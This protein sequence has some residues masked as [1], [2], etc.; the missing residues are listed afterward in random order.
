LTI[1]SFTTDVG[2]GTNESPDILIIIG[3]DVGAS[4]IG[5]SYDSS[6]II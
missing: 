2:S 5:E 3:T 6:K 4:R 1:G